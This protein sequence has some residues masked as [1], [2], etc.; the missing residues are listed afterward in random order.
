M[1]RYIVKFPDIKGHEKIRKIMED[2]FISFMLS[3]GYTFIKVREFSK[4][5]K[6]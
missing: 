4:V 5:A 3:H 2:R 6:K 1:S